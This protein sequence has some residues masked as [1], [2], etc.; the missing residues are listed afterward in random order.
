[1]RKFLFLSLFIAF[2]AIINLSVQA[3]TPK[4]SVLLG[5]VTSVSDS[6]I[7]LQT[8]DGAVEVQLA[9]TTEYKRVSPER[10][11]LA[12][13][14]D[15]KLSEVAVGDRIAV[16]G[17]LADDKK[18]M[19][20]AAV[21][22]MTKA[23]I[24]KRN[25]A[26]REAWK[27]RS[28][29]GRVVSVN[30]ET[31]QFTIASRGMMGEQNIVVSPKLNIS[32]RRYAP[33]SVKFDDAKASS[34]AE[35]K[36]GDQVRAL[37]DK[38]TDGTTFR[39]E[40]IVAGSFKTI[41]GTITAI[42]AAKNEITIKDIQSGKPVTITVNNSTILKK[43]PPEFAQMMSARMNGG[44]GAQPP[45]GGNMQGGNV[46]IVRPPQSAGGQPSGGQTPPNGTGQGGGMRGGRGEF[47][48]M[49]ER[50]PTI[51]VAELK[52][53]DAIAISSSTSADPSKATAI[54]LVSGVEPFLR[55]QTAGGGR[56][57]GGGGA[58]TGFTIPGLDGGI[59][60]P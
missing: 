54:K 42:D 4:T 37:G 40:R 34:F 26:D 33:D 58:D 2:F 24:T 53:G 39:A 16:K 9:G 25:D 51:T 5:D 3:Q 52:V 57:A 45:A 20:A 18:S 35:L 29:S 43:F 41:G 32:Y 44:T 6:K 19:P 23:D 59:G 56:R 36:V 7:V 27:T 50:F 60:T 31:Q 21:Y 10:P 17:V 47:D 30:P 49:L 28:I 11:S 12:T 8:K 55:A 22:L 1:M 15:S 14:V 13:A 48:D 46:T 38:G